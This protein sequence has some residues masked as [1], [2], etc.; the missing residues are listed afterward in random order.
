L[1]VT[2]KARQ[3]KIGE[4]AL[5][6]GAGEG[7]YSLQLAKSGAEVVAADISIDSLKIVKKIAAYYGKSV[8]PAACDG[9]SLP[10]R[11]GTFDSVYCL[12]TLEHMPDDERTIGEIHRILKGCGEFVFSVPNRQFPFLWDPAK[13]LLSHREKLD[14]EQINL[15]GSHLPGI[16]PFLGHLRIYSEHE[17][18]ERIC[19]AHLTKRRRYACGHV[20]LTVFLMALK[21]FFVLKSVQPTRGTHLELFQSAR[22]RALSNVAYGL[23][24]LEIPFTMHLG[25]G[26]T[27]FITGY[28]AES[29]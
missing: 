15:I 2:K 26:V 7:V 1:L 20:L 21:L 24:R 22:I 19:K 18:T 16:G 13:S 4:L 27:L 12:E 14:L 25:I 29:N 17:L 6:L 11:S 9:Q 23:L 3:V 28:K 8:L 10:F 5:D